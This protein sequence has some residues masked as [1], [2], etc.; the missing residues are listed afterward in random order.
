MNWNILYALS[1]MKLIQELSVIYWRYRL[2]CWG[3][4]IRLN[5]VWHSSSKVMY[6][7]SCNWLQRV[8]VAV[9]KAW[10]DSHNHEVCLT[11]ALTF[12][13]SSTFLFGILTT[14]GFSMSSSMCRPKGAYVSS[15]IKHGCIHSLI[16]EH[17]AWIPMEL[18][19]S[20]SEI[21]LK[22]CS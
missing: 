12:A 17:S 15:Q 2:A 21:P 10:K 14:T 7:M 11:A 18:G 5:F 6:G 20:C 4:L 1:K 19:I 8:I 22:T 9:N 13:V 16:M 3:K